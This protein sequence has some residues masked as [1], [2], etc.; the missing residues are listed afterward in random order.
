MTALAAQPDNPGP[1]PFRPW[2]Q[3]GALGRFVRGERRLIACLLVALTLHLPVLPGFK[4]LWG[5]FFSD[6]DE[7]EEMGEAIVPIELDVEGSLEGPAKLPETE[8]PKPDPT[9]EP[10][11]EPAPPVD[12]GPKEPPKDAG[13][14]AA[15]DAAPPDAGPPDAAPPDAGPDAETPDKKKRSAPLDDLRIVSQLNRNPNNVQVVFVGS[16][17]RKHPLGK[18]LGAL[19]PTHPQWQDFF[20][21]THVDPIND[22]DAMV[23]T[24]PQFRVTDQVIVIMQFADGAKL[25]PAV[26]TLLARSEPKG[27]WL[28]DV[29]V[30]AALAEANHFGRMLAIVP[31]KR[32]LYVIPSPYPSEGRKKKQEKL[33]RLEASLAAAHKR[34]NAQLDRV[35]KASF[36]DYS[37][38]GFAIDAFMVQPWKLIS[39]TGKIDVPIFGE[40]EILP[41]TLETGRVTVRLLPGGGAEVEVLLVSTDEAQA[42]ADAASLNAIW[43]AARAAASAKLDFDL[44]EATFEA[45]GREVRAKATMGEELLLKAYKLAEKEID[46]LKAKAAKR[47]K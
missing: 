33:G 10:A 17:L 22:V 12:A 5:M 45:E 36:K 41:K 2:W 44:P 19:L 40:I 1:R 37:S 6:D 47:G 21:G 34:A 29:P 46:E 20:D 35:K 39:K 18:K 13:L 14:D 28:K 11:T 3:R 15:P 42:K 8:P 25:K 26:E 32:L 43:P 30:E 23:I 7:T 4:A 16:E 31:D 27:E 24:G 9:P 38:A